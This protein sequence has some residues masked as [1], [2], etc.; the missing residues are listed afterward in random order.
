MHPALVSPSQTPQTSWNLAGP[1]FCCLAAGVW[2]HM[3]GALV[4]HTPDDAASPVHVLD[5]LH[6]LC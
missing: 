4:E 3:A 6:V 1:P 2:Q 5:A